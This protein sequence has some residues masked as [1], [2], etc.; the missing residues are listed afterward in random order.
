MRGNTIRKICVAFTFVLL[1][2]STDCK[3]QVRCGCGKD[4]LVD[5]AATSSYIY[6]TSSESIYFQTEGDV[7]SIYYFC[8]PS[9]MYPKLANIKSG[10]VVQ[11]TGKVYWDCNYV[12][13]ASN[14]QY[15]SYQKIYNVQVTDVSVDLYGKNKPAVVPKIENYPY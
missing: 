11:I 9:E 5:L 2:V 8:N 3:K 14:S 1:F 12:Y 10:D 4:V 7:Y 13:Q 15:S 6:W